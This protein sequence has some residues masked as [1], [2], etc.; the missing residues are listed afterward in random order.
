MKKIF[1]STLLFAGAFFSSCSKHCDSSTAEGAANCTCKLMKEFDEAKGDDDKTKEVAAA[2]DEFIREFEKN[3]SE[4]L[5]TE[6]EVNEI[7]NKTE[8]CK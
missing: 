1:F 3:I 5:Y 4:G 2:Y 7:I 6:E 8:G